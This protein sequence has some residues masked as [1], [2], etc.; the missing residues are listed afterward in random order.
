MNE[1]KFGT[2]YEFGWRVCGVEGDRIR[3]A[4]ADG[5]LQRQVGVRDN[6]K[7][8]ADA[9][10]EK[11]VADRSVYSFHSNSPYLD[12]LPFVAWVHRMFDKT[13]SEQHDHTFDFF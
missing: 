10:V 2:G 13:A 8:G 6:G 5:W 7:V 3:D 11:D 12:W 1:P 4:D 9:G